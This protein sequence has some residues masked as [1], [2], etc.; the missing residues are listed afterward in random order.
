MRRVQWKSKLTMTAIYLC[1]VA[2][3]Y[4]LRIPCIYQRLFGMDC[5]GC[6]M[7]RALLSVLR[8]DF[9]AAFSYHPMFWSLPVLYVYFLCDGRVFRSKLWNGVVLGGIGLGFFV[10]WILKFF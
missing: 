3:M 1:G 6:G 7:T 10:N 4:L 2:G 5:I 9:Y 8:L